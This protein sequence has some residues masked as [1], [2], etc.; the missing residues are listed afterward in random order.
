M[1]MILAAPPAS[2]GPSIEKMKEIHHEIKRRL[3]LGEKPVDISKALGMTQSWLSIV[4]ASPVFQIELAKER[5]LADENAADVG[6]RITRLAPHAMSVLEKIVKEKNSDV[7]LV[8]QG[9]FALKALELAGHSKPAQQAPA[10]ANV[11]VEIVQF[12][13]PDASRPAQQ[14]QVVIDQKPEAINAGS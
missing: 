9:D 2:Q 13:L 14:A 4:M 8:K 7:S 10:Q 12:T 11:R 5:A 1:E 6:G 3:I